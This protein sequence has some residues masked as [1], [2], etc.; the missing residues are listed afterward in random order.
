MQVKRSD[1]ATG[2]ITITLTCKSVGA[3]YVCSASL[4]P[5]IWNLTPVPDSFATTKTCTGGSCTWR[6]SNGKHDFRLEAQATPFTDD[7]E[8]EVLF[9]VTVSQSGEDIPKHGTS[10]NPMLDIKG[11][12]LQTD[13]KIKRMHLPIS[14]F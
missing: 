14:I 3:S 13:Y 10:K 11:T 7:D 6:A 5:S 1:G 8:G 12:R 4:K 2:P 9:S